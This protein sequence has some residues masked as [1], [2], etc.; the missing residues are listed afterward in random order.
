MIICSKCKK[1]MFVDRQYSKSDHLETYCLYC[2]SRKFFHPPSESAEG[3]W[4]LEKEKS[5]A[6]STMSP[7]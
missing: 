7:L 1:R 4:L 3:K 2:G 5:L 6:K